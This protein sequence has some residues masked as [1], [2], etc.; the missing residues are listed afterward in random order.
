MALI[1]K[2]FKVFISFA[3]TMPPQSTVQTRDIYCGGLAL[4]W[5][6]PHVLSC[7]SQLIITPSTK[8]TV[9]W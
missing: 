5:R 2:C 8:Q 4:Y 7:K 3:A 1:S 6:K 9:K